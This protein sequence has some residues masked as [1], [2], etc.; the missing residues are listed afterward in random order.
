MWTALPLALRVAS[1]QQKSLSGSS[2]RAEGETYPYVK[3]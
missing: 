3:H 1:S 2:S